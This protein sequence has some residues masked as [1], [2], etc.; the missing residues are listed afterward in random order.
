[1]V[2]LSLCQSRLRRESSRIALGALLIGILPAIH[3]GAQSAPSAPAPSFEVASIRVNHSASGGTH[4]SFSESSLR[5]S[6]ASV[7]N[8]I[9]SAYEIQPSQLSGGPGWINTAR[10]DIN[11]KVEDSLV[12]KFKT[13]KPEEGREQR[14]LLL[15]SLLA[16]RFNLKVSRATKELPIY[17]LVVAKSGIKFPESKLDVKGSSMNSHSQGGGPVTLES[18]GVTMASLAENLSRQVDR[19]VLDRT[20]LAGRYD[21]TLQY[22][23]DE[24]Q[25][26]MFRAS[27]SGSGAASAPP[28]DSAGPTIF[29]ALQEQLGLKLE[30]TKGPVDIL[31]ID[32]IDMP[33]ED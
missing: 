33:T 15:Q 1:M 29:T 20:G 30:A 19:T 16:E 28:P 13:L 21:F 2:P 10:F 18:K 6:N 3:A 14:K 12:E 9:F 31:V 27:D 23:R 8:L 17:A 11:A 32:H 24:N 4:I 5:V 22:S 7:K 25:G 26:A